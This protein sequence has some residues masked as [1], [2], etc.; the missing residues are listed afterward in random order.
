MAETPDRLSA[1]LANRYTIERELG[2]G[3]MG[4]QI[5]R[6]RLRIPSLSPSRP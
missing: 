1:P 2:A 5:A 6:L 3:G 4:P